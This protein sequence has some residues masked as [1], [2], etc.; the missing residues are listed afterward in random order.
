MI[1]LKSNLNERHTNK[2][3]HASWITNRAF[4]LIYTLSIVGYMSHQLSYLESTLNYLLSIDFTN[5]DLWQAKYVL[6]LW[7]SIIILIPFDLTT[8]DSD[9]I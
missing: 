4:Y 7:L 6:C 1:S 2:I 8:V 5:N 9:E 3:N